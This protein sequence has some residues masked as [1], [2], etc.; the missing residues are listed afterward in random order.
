MNKIVAAVLVAAVAVVLLPCAFAAEKGEVMMGG[1]LLMRIR[2]G[3]AQMTAEQRADVIQARVNDLLVLG[4]IDLAS[5]KVERQ[6]NDAVLYAG[7]KVLVTVDKCLAEANRTTPTRLAEVWAKRFRQIY[8][9][10]VPKTPG[11]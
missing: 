10:V 1:F 6:W 11:P 2:C 9:Q 4:G 8:P 3:T 7:G 5:V